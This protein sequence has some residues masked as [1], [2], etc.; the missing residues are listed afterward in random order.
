MASLLNRARMTT[1]TAGTGTVT[2]G[3]AVTRFASFAEAGAAD[4]TV[5]HYL[6]EDGDDFEVGLGTYT[7]AGT[8]FSR[9]TVLLSKIAGVSGTTKITLSGSAT[10]SSALLAGSSAS[11]DFGGFVSPITTVLYN[12]SLN[13]GTSVDIDQGAGSW[14]AGAT[15]DEIHV[16]VHLVSCSNT[17]GVITIAISDDGGSTYGTAN[18]VTS[19]LSN[20]AFNFNVEA[21]IHN[22][23]ASGLKV[24]TAPM[25]AG[26][27]SATFIATEATET[28]VTTGIQ[29]AI[30]S[31]TF[32]GTGSLY[33][34]GKNRLT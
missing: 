16:I 24:V 4:A 22:T 7:S 26:A 10:V 21:T 8:T 12:A 13:S 34:L 18:G 30:T 32:D 1:S 3:S 27:S 28:G 5:Y 19:A 25:I 9:D 20:A 31:G 6:I 29:V 14:P 2:L 15:Y 11:I 33:V 23:G 17:T